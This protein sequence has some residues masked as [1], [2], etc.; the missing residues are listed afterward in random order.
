MVQLA[1]LDDIVF[2]PVAQYPW[3]LCQGDMSANLD[4]LAAGPSPTE[5]TSCKIKE[6]LGR[7]SNRQELLWGLR[8]MAEVNWATT[9][10]E[11]QH[12]SVTLMQRHHPDYDLDKLLVRAGL[13]TFRKLLPGL[14]PEEKELQK[15]EKQLDRL[16]ARQPDKVSG[17]LMFFK[18]MAEGLKERARC[19]N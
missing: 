7:H 1:Y 6:L 19:Q 14:T 18:N 16:E 10:T 8:L 5:V 15:L 9:T 17:R 11:Q 3:C 2:R 12:A 4:A 13:H